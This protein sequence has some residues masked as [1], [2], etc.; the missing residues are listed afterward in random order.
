MMFYTSRFRPLNLW[1]CLAA[2][3]FFGSEVYAQQIIHVPADQPTIQK[4]ISAAANGDSVL[5]SPGTYVE[6]VDFLGK[7]ITVSS[8]NGPI[9]TIIDGNQNGIVVNFANGEPRSA[10]IK[11]FTIRNSGFP[12][13]GGYSDGIRIT[14]ASPTIT[15][16]IIT[17]NRGYG[18][19]VA[20]GGPLIQGNTIS[21]T[22]TEYDPTQDFGCDYLAVPGLLW[23]GP[24]RALR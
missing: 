6:N 1:A 11:G 21:Y 23:R 18:I 20:G 15:G 9:N 14:A 2:F 17:Q 24:P 19:E 12:A 4:A 16:N 13:N 5:V 10:L 22:T 3:V 8:S 7:A